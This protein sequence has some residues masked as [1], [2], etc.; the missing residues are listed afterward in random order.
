MKRTKSVLSL[1]LVFA[2]F[3]G[4]ALTPLGSI[5]GFAAAESGERDYIV[6]DD[7]EKDIVWKGEFNLA[8]DNT[9][10]KQGSSS[11]ACS[12]TGEPGFRRNEKIGI[13]MPEDW[14]EWYLEMW[15]YIDDLE[16]ITNLGGSC[17]EFSQEQDTV[18]IQWSFD[19]LNLKSGWNRIQLK[20]DG[21]ES[22]PT[23]VDQFETIQNLRVWAITTK[24]VS[25][26]IDDVVLVHSLKADDTA[27]LDK[28]LA[29]ADAL[30]EDDLKDYSAGVVAALKTAIANAKEAKT[31]S[32]RSVD[33]AAAA[34]KDALVALNFDG[35]LL[36]GS[37]DIAYLDF[38]S[39]K[40]AKVNNYHLDGS[41]GTHFN[42]KAAELTDALYL[43]V[44]KGYI[45]DKDA[46]L[47]ITFA[48][49]DNVKD[50]RLRLE[51]NTA[52]KADTS[53]DKT[54]VTLT[55]SNSW[56]TAN[57]IVEDAAF[58]G[59]LTVG[60]EG[61]DLRVKLDGGAEKAY[62][63][64]LK[65]TLY[66]ENDPMYNVP[67]FAPQTEQNNI[68][69][70]S[71][72]GYQMWFGEDWYHN[73]S[74]SAAGT[75]VF[76]E[77]WP[78][79]KDYPTSS[80]YQSKFNNLNSGDPSMLF[81]SYDPGI[82]DTHFAWMEEYGI[83]GAAIQRFY[84]YTSASQDLEKFSYL[85]TAMEK[86]EAHGR[87]VYM[88]YDMSGA[89][90]TDAT[91]IKR[92]QLDFVYNIEQQ[93]VVSSKAYAHAEGK[94]V[95]C[96][97]GLAGSDN[98][99]S[100]GVAYE[101]VT[102]FQQRGYFVIV[103]TPDNNF[104]E[105]TTS[106]ADV[107]KAADM[108]SPWMVGR[109]GPGD[110]KDR[111]PAMLEKDMAYCEANDVLYQPCM[112]PGFSWAN[113]KKGYKYNEIARNSGQFLWDQA[114]IIAE[115]GCT[116][117]YYS[118]FDEYD[119]GSN[120]MK[121]AQ[122]FFDIPEGLQYFQTFAVDGKWL[123]ADFYL[124]A[125]QDA[126][127]MLRDVAS[128]KT[129]LE[130]VPKD[131]PTL[132]S[133]GPI[134]YRNSFEK[135]W[136]E[137]DE[138]GNAITVPIDAIPNDILEALERPGFDFTMLGTSGVDTESDLYKTGSWSYHYAGESYVDPDGKETPAIYSVLNKSN[139]VVPEDL[140]LEYSVYA[141]DDL[142][143]YVF[144]DLLFED[145]KLLSDEQGGVA[146]RIGKTGEWV[147]KKLN[148]SN[149]FAGKKVVGIVIAYDHNAEG[150]FSAFVDDIFVQTG[151]KGSGDFE[152]TKGLS[153]DINGDSKVD[154]T[155]ARMALQYAV[156]KITLDSTQLALGD[157][158]G[159]GKVDTTDARLI[160]QYA[161]GKITAFPKG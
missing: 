24:T 133:T 137:A 135:A 146:G 38:N 95:V 159:D 119:E 70:K 11:L 99:A 74:N 128:G 36:D 29:I 77:I 73:W 105:D 78:Y 10:K 155:D 6:L 18:E 79:T 19:K 98:Y 149:A 9:D 104:S 25:M 21:P 76:W 117:I 81:N 87:S 65:V 123:S 129:K 142:G 109:Y 141:E 127:Q 51:Y 7:C 138:E 3:F 59:A 110:V 82:I 20:L 68:I 113:L 22:G 1:L 125:A 92:M 111:L 88:M 16:N 156:G 118:M 91:V 147:T 132:T 37:S 121:G 44:D 5:A 17:I 96:L 89:K 13:A 97:W 34:L 12:G 153:G 67:E 69:G 39:A 56:K 53:S 101:L 45:S 41:L 134:Y 126:T 120:F 103:G 28:Q 15:L 54:V 150:N 90:G 161:V 55:G 152:P 85:K 8:L 4:V 2:M 106:Y 93:G 52:D 40:Y 148:V 160:L 151:E 33:V 94:P 131:V 30:T 114:K 143:T 115:Y 31:L 112:L 130:N 84:G 63:S 108:I 43:A 62:I 116:N 60:D 50:A 136:V 35:M 61:Y 102:W 32:Q 58:A 140:T 64:Q 158:N 14:Q 86:A 139:F 26:K 107:Y 46:K 72:T 66:D 23:A 71:I 157:V 80:L 47:M 49:Y 122:D 27:E 42:R 83:D 100:A 124:R 154:T 145:G 48:Y 75:N 57:V 144:I